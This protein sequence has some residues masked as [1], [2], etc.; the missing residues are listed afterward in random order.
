MRSMPQIPA[1]SIADMTDDVELKEPASWKGLFGAVEGW[2]GGQ[3]A[4]SELYG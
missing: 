4:D 1:R 2:S 3:G